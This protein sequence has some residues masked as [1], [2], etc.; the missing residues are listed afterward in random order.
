MSI[1]AISSRVRLALA[2]AAVVAL[3]AAAPGRA[4]AQEYL[5][6]AEALR[7]AFPGASSIERRT[8]FLDERQL[9]RVR[10]LAG[11]GVEV[12]QGVVTYYVG[13]RG[14]RPMGAAY[15]DAHRVRTLPEV[16]MIVVSP[17]GAVDRIEI[18]KFSEPPQYRPPE[19]WLEHLEGR[20]LDASLS[21]RGGVPALTGATLTSAAVTDAAR[22]VLALHGVI[23]P[24]QVASGAGR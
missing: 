12:K 8:A 1:S 11:R 13:M 2:A 14:G 10:G 17:G 3:T 20:A 16:A 21:R 5:T 23:A 4:P 18:L 24:F 7:L 19:G 15:F 9:A 6:Q 22:R